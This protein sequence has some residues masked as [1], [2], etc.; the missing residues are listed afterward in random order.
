MI[1]DDELAVLGDELQQAGD[2]LGE[3]I[4]VSLAVDALPDSAPPA[5]RN[6]LERK[7]A[8]LRDHHHDTL[9]GALAPDVPRASKP[10]LW[11]PGLIVK[12]WHRGFAHTVWI[13][14]RMS[15]K[16]HADM[17]RE[18]RRLPIARFVRRIELG[19]GDLVAAL[20][21]LAREPLRT[22]RELLVYESSH[23]IP[24]LPLVLPTTITPIVP[25]LDR[26]EVLRLGYTVEDASFGAPTMRE[27][28]MSLSPALFDTIPFDASL[29][30][31]EDLECSG[32]RIDREFFRRYPTLRRL[33][34]SARLDGDWLEHVLATAPLDRL[35]ILSLSFGLGDDDL[36]TIARYADRI[37]HLELFSLNF[38]V[39]SDE[40]RRTVDLPACVRF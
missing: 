5:R 35:E 25:L 32:F 12:R 39:F 18:L 31:I 29:P 16:T 6:L 15:G 4:A 22:A 11:D 26:L 30:A 37:A 20:T 23:D 17:L 38:N 8:T 34:I 13:Q 2:P 36:R 19:R 3:L 21:D 1:S 40:A 28:S 9:Y 24:H 14:T 33:R 27:L 7:L 10:D